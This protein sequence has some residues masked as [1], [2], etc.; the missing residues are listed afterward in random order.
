MTKST[1]DINEAFY[2]ECAELDGKTREEF[3][4]ADAAFWEGK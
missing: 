3:D 1:D 2:D 4:K